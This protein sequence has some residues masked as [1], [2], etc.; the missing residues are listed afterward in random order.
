[1][2][3][4]LESLL[5]TWGRLI[6]GGGFVTPVLLLVAVSLWALLGLRALNLRRGSRQDVAMLRTT[7]GTLP[8]TLLG[9]AVTAARQ[10]KGLGSRG[11]GRVEEHCG[12]L[13]LE[14][15]Q[16]RRAVLV[17]TAVAPLLGLLGTVVGM[18]ETFDGLGSMTLFAQSGGVAGGVGQA[19]LSTQ[20]GLVVA[21]PGLLIGRTLDR[22]QRSLAREFQRLIELGGTADAPPSAGGL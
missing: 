11:R 1:M 14:A 21:V 10:A 4:P 22:R 8:P 13:L 9:R 20:V 6:G 15:D 16:G 3:S 18:I 2:W 7:T 19:L 17:L 5:S 12:R